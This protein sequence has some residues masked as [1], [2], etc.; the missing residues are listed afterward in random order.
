MRPRHH[1]P[2][3]A[4]A[5]VAS[6]RL[7]ADERGAA[8][9]LALMILVTLA[10]LALALLSMSGFE[11]QISSNHSRTIRA[12]YVA[13]AGLE[14]AYPVLATDPDAWNDYLTGATCTLGALLGLPASNLPGLSGAYGA[15]SVRIRN[16]CGPDDVRVTG[17]SLD[18]SAG[19]CGTVAGTAT[20]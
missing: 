15:F 3:A 20:H 19:P 6:G 18:T 10:G 1:I 9:V 4:R 13:E 7:V 16:D 17:M 8:L 12:R 11:P 14:Y 5:P 2:S